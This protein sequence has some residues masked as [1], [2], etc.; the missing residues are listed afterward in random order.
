MKRLWAR[1]GISLL[2][3]EDEETAVFSNDYR[4]SCAAIKK[5][6]REGRFRT[7][8]DS[9]VPGESVEDFNARYGTQYDTEGF[10]FGV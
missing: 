1:L 4:T 10:E 5:I 9:Y 8:G 2:I 7:D 3:E 6:M